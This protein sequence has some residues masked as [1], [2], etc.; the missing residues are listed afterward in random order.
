MFILWSNTQFVGLEGKG[1]GGGDT[2]KLITNP[3]CYEYARRLKEYE[4]LDKKNWSGY[5]K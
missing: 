4:N 5:I 3:I 1:G 2:L